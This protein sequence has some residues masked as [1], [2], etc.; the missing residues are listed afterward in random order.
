V[1]T[2]QLE[3]T[4]GFVIYD[5]PDADNYV[6]PARLGAK[7]TPA[8]AVMLVRH[9]TYVFAVLEQRRSGCTIGFKVDPDGA[10]EAIA[11]AAGELAEELESQKLSTWPDLRLDSELLEPFLRHD[12]RSPL[13]ASDRDGISF[14]DEL[15]GLGAVTAAAGA[16]G[17][18]D[19]KRVAIEGFDASGLGIAR[20]VER[21]G[22][23]VA[24]IATAKGCVSGSFDAATLADAWLAA[25]P[26]CVEQLGDLGKPWEIWKGDVD[27]L[28]VGSKPGAMSGQGAETV[29]DT[30]VVATSAAAISSKALAVM[31]QRNTTAV[32]DFVTRVGPALAWWPDEGADHDAVRSATTAAVEG[33]MNDT[34]GHADGAFMAA[35]YRAESFLRSWQDELP[36]GRPMG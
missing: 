15:V 1:E 27:A 23:S 7:L 18:I 33:L 2:K 10:A 26:A 6:G 4:T 16:A 3:A 14:S 11:A 22:G 30:V 21:Q 29:G 25:G 5:L 28:F 34:A 31:R 32:A 12:G 17:G 24:R 20:E 19:G 13:A 8:N 36:F 35:C 9:Q